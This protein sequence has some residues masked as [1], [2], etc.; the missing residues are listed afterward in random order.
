MVTV[1]HN[2]VQFR[3][4]RPEAQSVCV[5]GD[6]SSP[7]HGQVRMVPVGQ[8]YWLAAMRLPSGAYRFRYH[9]DGK[10]LTDSGVFGIE[11]GPYSCDGVVC[12]AAE[13]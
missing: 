12:V 9:V 10:W 2:Y 3:Y 1:H 4:F 11:R 5:V 6:F 13:G 8:G 7:Q